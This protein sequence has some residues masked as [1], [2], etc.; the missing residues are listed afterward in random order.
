M[1]VLVT[2]ARGQLGLDTV[3]ALSDE[4]VVTGLGHDELD[5]ADADAVRAA[6]STV[7][8]GVVVN[9][10]A[11]TA[12]D[13][14]EN[15]PDRAHR[16][17]AG[18]PANLVAALDEFGGHLIQVSTDY[19]FDGAKNSP[20]TACDEPNPISVYGASKLAGE[21]AC[22]ASDTVVRTSWLMGPHPPNI[23]TTILDLLE[24]PDELR[25]VDDQRGCPTFTGDLAH[26]LGRLFED[27]P[28]GTIHMT[29]SGNVTWYEFAAEVARA[30]GHGPGRVKPISSSQQ[31]ATR[32]AARPAYS[33]LTGESP[34]S[35]GS[36]PLRHYRDALTETLRHLQAVR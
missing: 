30:C 9:C 8:P 7:R 1:N 6:I 20:Y 25:F 2:G 12:V 17:N 13:A 19:V 24:G 34:N 16:I 18:G 36:H 15:D 29:N 4:H 28:A 26:A 21:Q 31:R 22:R 33:V 32:P 3:A 35:E 14:C 23:L 10:A 5:V 11:W 27:R